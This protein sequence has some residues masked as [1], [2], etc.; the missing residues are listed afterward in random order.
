MTEA[1]CDDVLQR[2]EH[3]IQ[4][5]EERTNQLEAMNGVLREAMQ[6]FVDRCARGEVKSTY[7]FNKF[8]EL[9]GLI[10]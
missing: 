8:R 10:D 6:E 7:T 4:L 9:L 5:L 2:W 1:E 3:H